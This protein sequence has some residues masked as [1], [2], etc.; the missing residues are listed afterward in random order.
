MRSATLKVARF[1]IMRQLKKPAF[2]AAT[3]LIPLLIGGIYLISF[4]SSQSVEQNPTIDENIK[5]A[6][7]DAAGILP[8]DAPY[9][10]N[11]DKEYG[12]EMVKNGEVDLYFYIPADFA[13]SK[14]AEFYHISEGLDIFNNDGNIFFLSDFS[15]DLKSAHT[16]DHKIQDDQIISL[17]CFF[18]LRE[19]L[20]DIRGLITDAVLQG[21]PH[22]IF[23]RLFN[24]RF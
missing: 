6:I 5:I 17:P 2:W 12:K 24:G 18:K 9:V 19:Q 15:A 23:T 8:S 16:G 20:K 4:I 14:K 13:E 10:I 21:V 1:E 22:R 7:T 3:L 11:G